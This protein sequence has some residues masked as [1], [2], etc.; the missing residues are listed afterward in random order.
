MSGRI[1][2]ADPVST[3]RIVLKVKLAAA[4]YDVI[5]AAGDDELLARADRDRPDLIILSSDMGSDDGVPLCQ[6]LGKRPRTAN[7]PVILVTTD[8]NP[9]LR[10]RGLMAG[11]AEVL[12][13]PLAEAVL[14][15][16]M[17]NLLRARD[18]RAELRLRTRT[19]QALG[20]AEAPEALARP[21]RITIVGDD[22]GAATVLRSRLGPH[23]PHEFLI[24]SR[25]QALSFRHA[26]RPHSDLFLILPEV[27]GNS[28]ACVTLT[29][30]RS[31]ANTRNAAITQLV[32]QG[33]TDA[34]T[35]ALD[36]GADDA[37]EIPATPEEL[38]LRIE[39]QLRRKRDLDRLRV[40][41]TA[42]LELA[43]T[44]PLT[45]LY[46]RRY[47]EHHMARLFERTRETRGMFCV[48][49]VDLDRF[50]SVNDRLGHQAGDEVLVEISQRLK[51]N[52]RAIDMISRHGGEEFV[53]TLPE[54]QL[55]DAIATAERLRTQIQDRAIRLSSGASVMQTI[56]IGLAMGTAESHSIAELLAVADRAL[57]A[58]KADGRNLVTV[59][60]NAA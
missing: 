21:A 13:K 46:N 40:S 25:F 49:L 35:M 12:T 24:E 3:N 17:R 32:R 14:L 20:F 57:Y 58:S 36:L 28:R 11:A 15:A 60:Q 45:G 43:A 22:D 26:E 33:D 54:T 31:R 23:L 41:V 6:A 52:L 44:D 30:L 39:R 4:C 29:D 7:I 2:V 1:L 56:S 50:K 53:I 10:T 59:G 19:N 42:G 51:R 34:L 47:A 9:E 18:T 55:E 38:A 16:R 48:M 5:Q 8:H 37:V 27:A